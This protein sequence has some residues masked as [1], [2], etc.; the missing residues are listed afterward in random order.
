MSQPKK[1]LRNHTATHTNK[2]SYLAWVSFVVGMCAMGIEM[3]TSRLMT[4]YFGSSLYTWTSLIGAIMLCLSVGYSLGGYLADKYE[5]KKLLYTLILGAG[6]YFSFMP[7]GAPYFLRSI[8]S[9][10]T[11][12]PL[13]IFFISFITTL[14]LLGIPFILVGIVTPYIIR[15]NAYQKER[16]GRTT[17]KI[18]AYATL[19][20]IIG[21]FIPVFLAIPFYGTKRTILYFG[22]LLVATAMVGLASNILKPSTN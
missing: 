16:L 19:G 14:L 17:G 2:K 20:S 8:L 5:S 11:T 9:W 1:V 6:I 21:T 18:A 10:I 12:H 13:S 7:F 3:A 22:L 4:P 15:L